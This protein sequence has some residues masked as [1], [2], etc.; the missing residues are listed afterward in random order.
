MTRTLTALAIAV[1][2]FAAYDAGQRSTGAHAPH[3]VDSDRE[4]PT[5]HLVTP[6]WPRGLPGRSLEADRGDGATAR[7]SAGEDS[8]RLR[9]PGISRERQIRV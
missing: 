9:G 7:D 6:V 5:R 3:W 8:V 4:A 2:L 1:L